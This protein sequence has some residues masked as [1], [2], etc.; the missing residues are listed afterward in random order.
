VLL[1]SA[2]TS[3]Q[4]EEMVSRRVAGVP[5]EHV[6]GW[7]DFADL[8]VW[9]D[10]GVFVPR[11]R[12]E[13][14]LEHAVVLL[15]A[16][17]LLEHAVAS[18]PR[19]DSPPDSSRVAISAGKPPPATPHQHDDTDDD[20]DPE[21]A[22][23]RLVVL[24]LCCGTGAI[25]LALVA[26]FRRRGQ[27]RIELHAAD[28][29]PAAVRCARRNLGSLGHAYEGDLYGP[30][31]ATLRGRVD[32]LVANAP[33]VPTEALGLLP[34]EARLHEP[35]IALNGGADGM[36]VLRRVA[37]E[38]PSWLSP[39]GHLL[40]EASE[41]QATHVRDIFARNGLTAKVVESAELEATV[42]IGTSRQR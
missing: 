38:A 35:R 6:V 3:E 20:T 32:I 24:D 17:L 19:R 4:L 7:A 23:P 2:T 25:G 14:L 12:T 33:Y 8:R 29:D 31:P 9:V 28:L 15:D 10:P 27:G 11:R 13:F 22:L 18:L 30:L 41:R 39:G 34:S 1:E 42:V 21:R 36:D 26:A 5:L 37:A 40:V 16:V